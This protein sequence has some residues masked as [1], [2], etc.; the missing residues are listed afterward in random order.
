[1][2]LYDFRCRACGHEFEALVRGAVPPECR[3][4]GSRD[5]ERLPSSFGV[6]SDSTSQRSLQ[7]ARKKAAASR[8]R[9]DKQRADAEYVRDH[10]K[11]EGVH[12]PLREKKGKP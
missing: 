2:P 10:Y 1:M 4:C 6:S 8:D 9:T 11:D 5:L 3:R 7:L 12:I